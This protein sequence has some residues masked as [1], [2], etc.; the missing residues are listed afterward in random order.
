[1]TKQLLFIFAF[2]FVAAPGVAQIG[3]SG[4]AGSMNRDDNEEIMNQ[5]LKGMVKNE[6]PTDVKGSPYLE[7]EF[8]MAK[9]VFPE[10][11]PLTAAVRYDVV[12]EEMQIQ[13]EEDTYRILHPGVVVEIEGTP[14]KMMTYRGENKKFDLLGYFEILTPEPD[15]KK[16]VL[17]KK[18]KKEV[19][20]GKAAAAMQKA[21]APRYIDKD[22]FYI[23]FNDSKP[24]MVEK[25][26]KKFVKLFPQEHQDEVQEFMKENNLK[27]KK[28]Q[29]LQSLVNYYNSNF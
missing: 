25:K 29:D 22:Y 26:T 3:T 10:N 7:S 2:L 21:T 4:G 16:L 19:R 14:F 23:R 6:T 8:E 12:K 27:P 24:V 1:M 18:Y 5:Y 28:Q 13:L 11:Q 9:L 20:R 15:S 17:L